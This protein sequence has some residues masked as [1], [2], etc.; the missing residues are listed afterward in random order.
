MKKRYI[1]IMM[2][3]T[4]VIGMVIALTLPASAAV[5]RVVDSDSRYLHQKCEKVTVFDTNLQYLVEDL[6]D[7]LSYAGD[8]CVGISAPEIGVSKRVCVVNIG[9]EN[10]ELINPVLISSKGEN[11]SVEGCVSIP[12]VY[13]SISRPTEIEI[14]YA[15]RYGVSHTMQANGFLARV[16]MH[17]MDHLDGVVITDYE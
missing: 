9:G 2:T 1:S 5:R 14:Q 8:G 12:G 17:E 6:C 3:L 13:V 16:I 15:D 7:T 10:L 11:S 4:A